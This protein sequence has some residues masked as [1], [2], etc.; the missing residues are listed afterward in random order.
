MTRAQLGAVAAMSLAATGLVLADGSGDESSAAVREALARVSIARP[1]AAPVA[2]RGPAHARHAAVP[3]DH[4]APSSSSADTT[5]APAP[6]STPA[7]PAPAAKPKVKPAAK[8]P[9]APKPSKVRHVFVVALTGTGVEPTFGDAS[10]ASYLAK[11]LRPKGT[12]L[13]NYVPLDNADL[14]NYLALVSGQPPNAD[15]EAE[16]ATYQDFGSDAKLGKNGVLS[17]DGCIY[18]NTVLTIGDRL[19]ASGSSWRAYSEDMEKGAAGAP[20]CRRPDLPGSDATLKGRP[21]DQYATRHNPF[22]YFHS[23]LDLGDCIANDVTLDKLGDDLKSVRTT[24]NLAFIAPN[25]C[26]SGTEL[27]CADGRPGGLAE[28]DAFL[29]EWIPKIQRSAA[30]R[31]DGLIMITFLSGP[32]AADPGAAPPRTGVLLLSRYAKAGST[33]DAPYDPYSLLRSIGDVFALKPLAKAAG[34]AS[35][36]AADLPQAFGH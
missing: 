24:P 21:D 33:D 35:F 28:V 34:A 23:A 6:V 27:P 11:E 20:A 9:A 1:A 10:P 26:N 7:A 3:V 2:H 5:S 22:V 29:H 4:P 36:A 15:T 16:C 18:P 32:P 8:A 25:L 13:D 19:T 14:T 30:Y 17:G 31:H 12:L